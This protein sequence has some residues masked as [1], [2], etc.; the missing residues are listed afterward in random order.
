MFSLGRRPSIRSWRQFEQKVRYK[1][2]NLLKRLD[3]FPNSILVAGCQ[4]SGTTA[5]ARII[6]KSDGIVNYWFGRDDELAA[7]LILS[8]HAHHKPKGRY[9]FQTTYLNN[10]YHE[11]FEHSDYKLV[12]VL[13]NPFSVVFSMLHNWRRGALN[14]LFKS[15]GASLLSEDERKR[16]DR[17]GPLV[18]SRLRRA[19]LAYNAKTSQIFELTKDMSIHRLMIIDYADLVTNAQCILPAIYAFINLEYKEQYAQM[20]HRDSVHKISHQSKRE[21][22]LVESLCLPI[23]LNARTTLSKTNIRHR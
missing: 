22:S 19:C 1:N 9:C 15:C 8:G 18:I 7:A 5:L 10:S 11:Y 2:H 6:T 13:R 4:R 21:S 3:E 20:I 17:F 16:F 12:W 14:R 23:Y